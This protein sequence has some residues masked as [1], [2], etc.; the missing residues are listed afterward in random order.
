M[1]RSLDDE[2]EGVTVSAGD[3]EADPAETTARELVRD[4]LIGRTAV[5]TGGARGIGRAIALRLAEAGAHVAVLDIDLAAASRVNEHITA[6]TVEDELRILGGDAVSVR[7]DLT[8][9]D[10]TTTAIDS[11]ARRWGRIDVL[12][13]VAGGALTDY[14]TSQ[15]SRISDT[16]VR[17]LLD[18]NVRTVVNA[19]RAAVPHM[20]RVSS[21]SIVTIT[22]GT[23]LRPLAGGF[24]S[25]YGASK[26]AVLQYTRFLAT[27]VGPSGIRVNSV[28]P[29]VIRTA[30][31]V[32]HSAISNVVS[33]AAAAA[34]PLR[35]QGE[36]E[37]VA[38]AVWF[39]ASPLSAYITGQVLPV[40]GGGVMH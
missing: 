20:S 23:A 16:D 21:G 37:D 35:R 24:L 5:V 3:R 25:G 11:V 10:A 1:R 2:V 19:C 26:A 30:R 6:E 22:S 40:N 32:A 13:T 27:E 9:A 8:D 15:A 12:V 39:L 7:C 17:R 28:A 38:N 31:V 29:G 34:L 18:V 33:D 14:T 36:V 4:S